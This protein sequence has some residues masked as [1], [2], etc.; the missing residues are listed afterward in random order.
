MAKHT[1]F[2]KNYR[3]YVSNRH[4]SLYTFF[5][6]KL[7][8]AQNFLQNMWLSTQSPIIVLTNQKVSYTILCLNT[9]FP[10]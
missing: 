9:K 1:V 7:G 8:R 4:F 6:R 10:I 3:N 2:F 5:Y